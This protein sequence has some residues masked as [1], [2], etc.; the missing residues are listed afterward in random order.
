M[1]KYSWAK[2]EMA[3]D[4]P[5]IDCA[6]YDPIKDFARDPSGCYVLIKVNG[7]TQQIEVAICNKDHLIEAVFRGVK[8]QDLYEGIFRH[9]KQNGLRWFDSKG[10]CAYLGKEL[11]KAEISLLSGQNNYLQE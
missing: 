9:E 8:A 6:V 3:D 4:C 5:H 1:K 2:Q 10:H 11:R 7:E